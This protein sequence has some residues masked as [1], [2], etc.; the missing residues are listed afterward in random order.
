MNDAL[1]NIEKI[2]E[3]IELGFDAPKAPFILTS[4]Y[5][6]FI[7]GLYKKLSGKPVQNC[8]EQIKNL[9]NITKDNG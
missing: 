5:S 3:T 9:M 2:K 4:S 1:K 8:D 7:D 6:I